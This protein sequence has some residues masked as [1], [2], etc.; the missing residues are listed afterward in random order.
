MSIKTH[1]KAKAI[2]MADTWE[3]PN[4]KG[5][6][7]YSA[8]TVIEAWANGKTEGQELQK[9]LLIQ[10]FSENMSAASKH[11]DEIIAI[12]KANNITP[13]TAH[14]RPNSIYRLEVLFT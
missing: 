13:L 11:T 12:L 3:L 4:D 6:K 14:L 1:S 7:L 5:E 9:K 2:E 8:D 10:K